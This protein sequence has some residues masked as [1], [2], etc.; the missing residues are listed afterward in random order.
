M[1]AHEVHDVPINH[2]AR[3]LGASASSEWARLVTI[4][5]L[6]TDRRP[7]PAAEPGWETL[8][9]AADPGA[10]LLDR[11]AAVATARRAGVQPNP[12]PA[13]IE[14]A[15]ADVRPSCP[16]DAA[17]LLAQMLRGEH[18]VLLPEWF[19]LCE[20]AHVQVAPHLIPALLLRGRRNPAFNV[21]VRRVIG[22][23]AAWLA[24]AMPE[25]NISQLSGPVPPGTAAFLPPSPP[26]DSGALVTAI[27]STFYDRA[28]TWAAAAQL[29]LAVASIDPVWLPALIVELQR[30][31]F[32]S[33]T[34]RTR[35]DLL[36]LALARQQL[37][38]CLQPAGTRVRLEP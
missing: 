2:D 28:A 14:P 37:V 1:T 34:E 5:I 18:D 16:P 31:P 6:G 20:L 13:R 33:V 24:E 27:S 7:L 35:V 19:A 11:A 29:R 9:A 23:R 26:S 36:G 38:S 32:S 10:E 12:A 15:P 3:E 25:L 22:A 8:T 21:V 4:A 30:A 17:S